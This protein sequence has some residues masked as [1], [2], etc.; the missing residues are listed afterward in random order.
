MTST[1]TVIAQ[2]QDLIEAAPEGRRYSELHRAICDAY[3]NIPPNTVHGSLHKFRTELPDEYYVPARGLYRHIKYKA[4]DEVLPPKD[5]KGLRLAKTKEEDFYHPFS[6]WLVNE[7]EEATKAIPLGGSRFKDKWG[8]PD[9]IAVREPKRSDVIKAPTE[10]ISAEIKLDVASLITAFGQCC[11]YKLFSHKSYLVI[12]ANSSEED[13]SRIDSLARIFGIGLV[14]FNVAD[15]KD[16]QF[17][18]RARLPRR[19][20]YVLRQQVPKNCRG[21]SLHVRPSRA[22]LRTRMDQVQTDP[23]CE[24][25]IPTR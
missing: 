17:T 2:A 9:V 16:P 11:S 18:I 19:A 4:T 20:G 3:P 13:L 12:P 21:R 10:I 8:T 5:G 15:P 1:Q 7:L 22:S 6:D 14:L 25:R 23:G 24:D